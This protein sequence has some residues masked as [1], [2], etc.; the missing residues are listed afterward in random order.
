MPRLNQEEKV[1]LMVLK[2]KNESNRSVARR[3]GVSEGTVRY[4]V[5]KNAGIECAVDGRRNKP[6]KSDEVSGVITGW[7]KDHEARS[8]GMPAN[9]KELYEWL[10]LEHEYTG[11]YKSIYRYIRSTYGRAP[12]RPYRRIEL[13]A[14]AQAQVDWCERKVWIGGVSERLYGFWMVLSHSRAEAL[15]WLRSMD[16]I[17]WQHGHNEAFRRL[18]GIPGSVRIDNLKT[19]MATAGP[20]G[21]VNPTYARYAYSVGFHVDACCVRHPEA[22]GKVENRIAK[23]LAGSDLSHRSFADLAELQAWTD[24]RVRRAAE[25]R[26]SPATGKS[27]AET[28]QVEQ[29]LLRGVD[30]LPEPFDVVVSRKVYKDCTV[31]FEGRLYSVPFQLA[32]KTVEV[33][34]GPGRVEIWYHAKQVGSHPRGT[35]ARV[36]L[37]RSHYEGE[38][39]KTHLRPLPLGQVGERILELAEAH[40]DLRAVDVYA[41]L[42]EEAG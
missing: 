19:G 9:V 28:L 7:L 20:Q 5:K 26:R 33:R 29:A 35:E 8:K 42:M 2:S 11:S 21:R 32:W 13:P 1:T 3:L 30:G 25:T 38:A 17:H 15:I 34:G 24:H 39:T 16:Q 6:R 4:H 37:D 31:S 41:A 12:R 27:V 36:V 18:G 14:G 22:K 10:V 40:V 23:L